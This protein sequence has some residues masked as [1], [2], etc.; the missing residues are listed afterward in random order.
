MSASPAIEAVAL[1][2]SIALVLLG[3]FFGAHLS[4]NLP[5]FGVTLILFLV[6]FRA[7]GLLSA[8]FVL[9]FKRAD[10]F[11]YALDM[12]SYLLCGIIYP[13]EVLPPV[14][15]SVSRLLPATYAIQ[16]L[17]ACGLDNAAIPQLLP[18][19]GALGHLPLDCGRL[20]ALR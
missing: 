1:W 13:V 14:L 15:R 8:A 3:V 10:P 6:A 2:R 18:A 4:V 5:A 19:W 7:L 20:P 11:S 17:R 9:T 12:V 16:A